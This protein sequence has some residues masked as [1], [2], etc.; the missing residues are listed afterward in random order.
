MKKSILVLLFVTAVIA[1][2]TLGTA[3]S[4]KHSGLPGIK[5]V[6]SGDLQ[7]KKDTVAKKTVY[8]CPMHSEVMQDKAGKCPKC[9]M[10][11]SKKEVAN[12]V[13]TCPMHPEVVQD[14]MGKCPKCGMN[15]VKKVPAKK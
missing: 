3:G 4:T 1:S 5:T 10:N 2:F 13:Y 6:L 15:L 14:K 12:T 11:L 7:Q 9:G 8:T